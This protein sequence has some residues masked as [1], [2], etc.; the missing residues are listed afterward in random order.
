MSDLSPKEPAEVPGEDEAIASIAPATPDFSKPNDFKMTI[1]GGVLENLGIRMYTKLGKVLVEFAANAYDSDSPFVD[2]VFDPNAIAT[3]RETVRAAALARL[4]EESKSAAKSAGRRPRR[5]AHVITD[6][7]PDA[8]TIIIRDHGHGMTA[9]E[10]AARFLPL[11]RNRR[12]ESTG[13]E[14]SDFYSEAGKRLVMGRKGIGKL[15]AFG[16]ASRMVIRSKRAAQPYWTELDLSA[17]SLM[18]TE[19]ISNVPIPHAYI[20]AIAA[21]V[22]RHGTEITLTGLRCDSMNFTV[23]EIE[24]VLSQ[25]FYPIRPEEFDIR[26]N[27]NAIVRVEPPLEFWYP[28]EMPR[29]AM[30]EG[31]VT[32][33]DWGSISFRYRVQFRENSLPADKRGVYLY[34]KKR[35]A[36][37]PTL[38]GLNTGM[39]NFM[40]HQYMECI[41]ESD[42]ID[43]LNIDI[44]GTNRSSVIQNSDLV[45]AFLERITQIMKDAVNAHSGFRDKKADEEIETAPQADELRRIL[46]T[47]APSQRRNA[48]SLARSFVSRFGAASDEFKYLTPLIIGTANAGEILIE[49]IKVSNSAESVAEIAPKLIELREIER[50]D[51]IK[52]YQG[53]RNGINGL[54]RIVEMSVESWGKGPHQEEELH[55]LLKASPWLIRPDLTGYISSN[56]GMTRVLDR[57]AKELGI[58]RFADPKEISPPPSKSD[59][60]DDEELKKTKRPDLVALLG[61]GDHPSRVFVV[62]LKAP[63]LALRIEHLQQLRTYMRKVREFFETAYAQTG[64][65]VAVEGALIGTMPKPDTKSDP[66]RDLLDEIKNRGPN[67]EWEVISLTEMLRRTGRVH[68]E[69]LEI[70]KTEADVESSADQSS[71][72][73]EAES[74]NELQ[75]PAKEPHDSQQ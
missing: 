17:G 50:S 69:M 53:R 7:L 11:N 57:L 47:I 27:E 45:R 43:N 54:Q 10:M 62:E 1:Q 33:P 5:K 46:G 15:S 73:A 4:A 42:D 48:R 58:D 55:H 18:V 65:R 34:S 39:H 37:E 12:K 40:A 75:V 19:N 59:T 25:T 14:E 36:M 41:V 22:P 60:P 9:Q 67:T 61:D 35:L 51:A 8:V 64:Y 74:L 16:V 6:P 56:E 72:P 21:D 63:T 13:S 38:L 24:E 49:L 70:L 29:N 3:A 52:L 68:S 28:P 66:Q 20:E 30:A 2:I 23:A 26:I 71:A 31:S 32:D 44:I